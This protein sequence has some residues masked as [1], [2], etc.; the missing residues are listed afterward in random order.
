VEREH[1]WSL[2][3][4]VVDTSAAV[5]HLAED[6]GSLRSEFRHDIRRL[7]DRTFKSS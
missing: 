2:E 4:V 1:A 3:G 6:V 7:D 5:V